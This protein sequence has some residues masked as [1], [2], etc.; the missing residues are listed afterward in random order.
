M[1]P[2]IL[3]IETATDACSVALTTA[4]QT[5]SKLVVAPQTHAKLLLGMVDE[6][7][8]QA[9]MQLRDVDALAFGRGPGSFT[10]VRIAA[11]VIQGLAFGVNKPVIPVSSLQALAQQAANLHGNAEILALI[12]ARMQE[13]YWGIYNVDNNGIVKSAIEDSLQKPEVL[14]VDPNT[15]YLAVGTGATVYADVLRQNNP[16]LQFDPNIQYPR[17]EEIL[18]IALQ[19]YQRGAVV[20]PSAAIPTYVRNDVAKKSKQDPSAKDKD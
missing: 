15:S 4:S 9:G 11:S 18:Q 13:V 3:A 6:L 7:C 19:E 5:Y 14:R 20:A 10:G 2:I 12:D 8:Q 16:N 1:N 17:A